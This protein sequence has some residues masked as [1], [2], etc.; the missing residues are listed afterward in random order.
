VVTSRFFICD[1][2]KGRPFGIL[3]G[4]LDAL[5]APNFARIEDAT[6]ADSIPL[7]AGHERW[8]VWRRRQTS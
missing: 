8:Q 1:Q 5:L 6:V 2:P 7:I 4:Q 3:P